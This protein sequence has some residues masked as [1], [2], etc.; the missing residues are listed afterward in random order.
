MRNSGKKSKGALISVIVF[1]VMAI[2][3]FVVRVL[4]KK[5]P[6]RGPYHY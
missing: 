3:A 5:E 6:I 2:V 4:T 1:A